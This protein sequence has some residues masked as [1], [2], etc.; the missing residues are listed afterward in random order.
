MRL[1]EIS[2]FVVYGLNRAFPAERALFS[3]TL[4]PPPSVVFLAPVFQG[5]GVITLPNFFSHFS[6]TMLRYFVFPKN[7]TQT[8]YLPENN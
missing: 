2:N 1:L 5:S 6:Q 7:T 4:R 3:P 8:Q